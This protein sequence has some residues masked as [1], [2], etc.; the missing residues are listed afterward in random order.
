MKSYSKTWITQLPTNLD[1][2]WSF[3]S[4]PKNLNL[5]TPGYMNFRILYIPESTGIYAGMI[6]RYKVS[7]VFHIPL[8]WTTEITEC[9]VNT[10][11]IDEQRT[12]P[13]SMWHHEHHFK[14]VG[15]Q[16]E[17]TDRLT[18]ALPLGYA[19]R[20]LNELFISKKID[21]IFAFRAEVLKNKFKP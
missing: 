20:I 9:K 19:G 10:Y 8:N 17:M 2:A 3:F 5:L 1:Q 7:P 18:Y 15:E 16:V 14:Q 12:G 13:Y 21:S 11:F 4:D 6:I